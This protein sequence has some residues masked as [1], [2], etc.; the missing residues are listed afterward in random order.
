MV[1]V[2]TKTYAFDVSTAERKQLR[3]IAEEL[4]KIEREIDE[5]VGSDY[6]I[7]VGG[8]DTYTGED[9]YRAAEL[10]DGIALG[11]YQI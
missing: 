9:L 6:P 5:V 4:R 10:L 3:D 8:C 1:L 7:E 11:S 2:E